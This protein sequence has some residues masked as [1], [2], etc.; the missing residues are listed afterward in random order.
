MT[1]A[2]PPASERLSLVRGSPLDEEPGLG[3]LTIAGYA[4]AV[5]SRFGD[6]E[7]LVMHGRAG[8]VSWSYAELWERSVEVAKALIAAGA[9]K[10]ARIGVLMTNR[11]EYLASVFGVALAGGVTVS[12]STF[13]TPVELE[14]LLQAGDRK[15]VV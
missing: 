2:T 6:R 13:S 9:G 12:L 1:R 8:R 14:Y 15:S 4:R 7:A 3:A 10:D 11:P 5:T